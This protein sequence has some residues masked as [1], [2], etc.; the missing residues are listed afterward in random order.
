MTR[1]IICACGHSQ[2]RPVGEINRAAKKG[3]PLYCSRECAGLARRVERTA[4]EKKAIKQAYDAE[5]RMVLAAELK[6]KAAA[7]HKRTY[8]PEKARI[9]RQA[10]MPR[11]V[12]YCRQPAY[13]AKKSEYDRTRR[14]QLQFGPFWE[15][16]LLTLALEAEIATRI[17]RYEIYQQNGTLNK[18][19]NRRREYDHQTV[20]R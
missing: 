15:S 9:E 5:R 18:K 14:A 8:D 10:K 20:S 7:Y 2:A 4:A 3:A 11:H 12:E 1:L 16:A 6:D 19:L 17:S 13:R